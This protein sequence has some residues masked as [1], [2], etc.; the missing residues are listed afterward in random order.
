M[1]MEEEGPIFWCF[2]LATTLFSTT[3]I[4]ENTGTHMDFVRL[5]FYMYDDVAVLYLESLAY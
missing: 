2:C 3:Y 1:M 5:P 4:W